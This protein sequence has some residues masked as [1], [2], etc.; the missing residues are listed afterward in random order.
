MKSYK[1]S[2]SEQFPSRNDIQVQVPPME[3]IDMGKIS[4]IIN[5]RLQKKDGKEVRL[6]LCRFKH[7]TPDDDKWLEEK[8]IP[9][10]SS[11]LR[12]WRHTLRAAKK[13]GQA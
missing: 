1:T 8:D 2:N 3:E 12:K 9:E 7:G 5:Q 11:L 10:A 4:Q 13:A 6:Y